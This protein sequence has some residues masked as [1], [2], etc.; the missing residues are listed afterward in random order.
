MLEWRRTS[1]QSGKTALSPQLMEGVTDTLMERA[2]RQHS[3]EAGKM[4]EV[5]G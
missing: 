5:C 4:K 2:L 1:R 3:L